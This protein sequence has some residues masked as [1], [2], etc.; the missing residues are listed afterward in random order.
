LDRIYIPQLTFTR[1]LAAGLIVFF[2]FGQDVYPFATGFLHTMASRGNLCV[3]YL[4]FLSGFVMTISYCSHSFKRTEDKLKY[5][6]TRI[7]RIYPMF[8]LALI[9]YIAFIAILKKDPLDLFDVTT[10]LFCLQAWI[11]G[12]VLRLNFPGWAVSVELF[13]VLLFPFIMVLYGKYHYKYIFLLTIMFW[14]SSL[15]LQNYLFTSYYQGIHSKTH[16][17]IFYNPV[18]HLNTFLFGI[19][20]GISYFKIKG[21]YKGY[22]TTLGFVLSVFAIY[23]LVFSIQLPSS[24]SCTYH[25]GLLAPLFFIFTLSL[26][27][28]ESV[29]SRILS[30]RPLEL[31]GDL[32]YSIFILQLPVAIFMDYYRYQHQNL[33]PNF[34]VAFYLY[35]TVL[36][37]ISF[38]CFRYF[39]SPLRIRVKQA[40]DKCIDRKRFDQSKRSLST[41]KRLMIQS[42]TK[43]TQVKSGK[44]KKSNQ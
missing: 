6:N 7:A 10:Q 11:P 4:F 32:S 30:Y 38:L 13:F 44:S 18:L 28:D 40:L 25:N 43:R 27:L 34:N 3:S 20:G 41:S 17:M 19:L 39:E 21:L 42:I 2:H 5:W 15:V 31:L 26:S 29:I 22:F 36:L 12:R 1:F 33:I 35:L 8:I 24:L 23:Y 9:S 16:D 37:A 14:I